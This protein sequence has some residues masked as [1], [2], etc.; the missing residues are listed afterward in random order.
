MRKHAWL[1]TNLALLLATIG[2][3]FFVVTYRQAIQDWWTLRQY[4]P[5]ADIEQIANETT[6][7]GRGRDLFY[8]S[9]PQIE[10]SQ[11]FNMHCDRKGEKTVV[12]GCYAGQRIYL[13][14]VTDPR[15]YGVKQVTA[16]HEMLHA[17]YERLNESDKAALNI[18]L[19]AELPRVTDDHLKE[20]IVLYAQTEPGEKLNEMHSILGTEYGNLS[21]DLE[22]YYKQY[23]EDRSKVVDLAHKYRVAFVA[24]QA[25]IE[26]LQAR[27]SALKRQIDTNSAILDTRKAEIDAVVARLNTLRATDVQ[28]YNNAVPGYNAQ[29]NAYNNLVMATRSLINQYNALVV[30]H[31]NEAAA[32]NSLYHNLDSRYQTVN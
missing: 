14:N 4:T 8:V 30:E 19:E 12:L 18:M 5:P 21:P 16:A 1:V 17:A 6:M 15:L 29:A 25:K 3:G 32:Q 22:R 13:F 24:S 9:Q 27:M 10:D 20:L 11:S 28:A 23:F 2:A 26:Q 31:N 7:V